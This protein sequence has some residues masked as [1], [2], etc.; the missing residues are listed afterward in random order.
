MLSS[1]ICDLVH[2]K[3]HFGVSKIC[4]KTNN[5]GL[6][7]W[8]STDYDSYVCVCDSRNGSHG[9]ICYKESYISILFDITENADHATLE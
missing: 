2:R 9:H 7:L 5:D 3:L 8:S 6:C 1:E 4:H